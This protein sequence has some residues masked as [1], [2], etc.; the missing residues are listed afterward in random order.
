MRDPR[1]P[2]RRMETG[3]T[4]RLRTTEEEGSPAQAWMFYIAL[5]LF[6]L[7]WVGAIWRVPMTRVVGGTDTEESAPLDVSQIEFGA[8]SM[9]F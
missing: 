2:P 8:F 5:V 7:W 4:L 1:Q 3:W 6:P 9:C